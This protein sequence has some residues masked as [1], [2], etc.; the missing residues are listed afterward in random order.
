MALAESKDQLELIDFSHS[1]RS[2]RMPLEAIAHH[3]PE[4]RHVIVIPSADVSD[5]RP[6][7]FRCA[8]RF[9]ELLKTLP[10]VADVEVV[11]H[12]QKG[13]DYEKMEAL[14]AALNDVIEH[15]LHD[16]GLTKRQVVIDITGGQGT[17]SAVG[18]LRALDEDLRFEY[19]STADYHLREYDVTTQADE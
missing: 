5:A 1:L 14:D 19:V 9:K 18:A 16:K 3:L 7:T 6:G 13:V 12:P 17:C 10:D 11:I 15:L 2:W 4:L 8:E